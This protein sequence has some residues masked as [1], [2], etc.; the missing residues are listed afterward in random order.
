MGVAHERDATELTPD[1]RFTS[2]GF[3]LNKVG[4]VASS[5]IADAL[6]TVGLS[7][8]QGGLLL[9]LRA[10]GPMTQGDLA[11]ELGHDPSTLVLLLNDLERAGLVRRRRDE[12]DRRR[13]IVSITRKGL[14][15]REAADAAV[16]AVEERLLADLDDDQRDVLRTLL[17]RIDARTSPEWSPGMAP[18]A[19]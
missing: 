3:L 14:A 13:H 9:T 4:V 6:A 8:R 15:R 5:W 19:R 11:R 10:R 1:V 18:P 16:T 7:P 2:P 17:L 12:D